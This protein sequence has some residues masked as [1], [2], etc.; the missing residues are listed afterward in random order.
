MDRLKISKELFQ[1]GTLDFEIADLLVRSEKQLNLKRLSEGEFTPS[2]SDLLRDLRKLLARS[3]KE[4]SYPGRCGKVK[5]APTLADDS[6]FEDR[7]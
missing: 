7:R 1:K 6:H 2:D 3:V 5:R 4:T